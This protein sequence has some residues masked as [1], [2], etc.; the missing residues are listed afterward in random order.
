MPAW[1]C[2]VCQVSDEDNVAFT[3]DSGLFRLECTLP[4]PT[5]LPAGAL[6]S[7]ASLDF[8]SGNIWPVGTARV[9]PT[10]FRADRNNVP[11]MVQVRW[12]DEC[13]G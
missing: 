4:S 7:N 5:S 8:R 13:L 2:A 11:Y 10:A 9:A 6:S 3:T 1:P 12:A